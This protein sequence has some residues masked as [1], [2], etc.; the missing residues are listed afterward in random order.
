MSFSRQRGKP[1]RQKRL[2]TLS[3]LLT[4]STQLVDRHY[5]HFSVRAA[6]TLRVP[7]LH[8]PPRASLRTC[9]R[10]P[11]LARDRV[12]VRA[13][14]RARVGVS[15]R[16]TYTPDGQDTRADARRHRRGDHVCYWSFNE[17]TE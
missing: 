12:H 17:G 9:P 15:V 8:F 3:N 4:N 5:S 6:T 11:T 16:G 10:A 2:I 13:Q 1:T 14:K 7:R